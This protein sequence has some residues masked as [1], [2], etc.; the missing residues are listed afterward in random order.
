MDV[1]D[2]KENEDARIA[3]IQDEIAKLRVNGK[4]PAQKDQRV[5]AKMVKNEQ[6]L[7]F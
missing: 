4:G 7:I 1:R 2:N 3:A 5:D 6:L